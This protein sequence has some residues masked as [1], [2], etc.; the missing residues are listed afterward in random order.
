M[1]DE[2]SAAEKVAI[3][4][5]VRAKELTAAKR[6]F[7]EGE[8]ASVD[9][10]VHVAGQVQKG[11]GRADQCRLGSVAVFAAVLGRLGIGAKR[12]RRALQEICDECLQEN[13]TNPTHGLTDENRSVQAV[14]DE[15]AK[16]VTDQVE[17]ENRPR[18]S[19]SVS[20]EVELTR[21]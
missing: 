18:R 15:V 4:G 9:V 16:T 13:P 20:T 6:E 5:A 17:P 12:L 10:T 11:L 14:F 19:G 8:T 2:F 21:V 1:S 7:R 3:A